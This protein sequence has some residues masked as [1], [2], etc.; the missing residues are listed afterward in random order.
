M[1]TRTLLVL[2]V[3]AL[4]SAPVAAAAINP[5]HAT[6]ASSDWLN[7]FVDANVD[8]REWCGDPP[9]PGG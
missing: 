3:L 5:E 7:C 1:N 9:A 8:W 4:A 6:D 2:L